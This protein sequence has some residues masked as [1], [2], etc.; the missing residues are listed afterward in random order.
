MKSEWAK[1]YS[2][3][4]NRRKL[5][6]SEQVADIR[7]QK[8]ADGFH[9]YYL[10]GI[11]QAYI[12]IIPNQDWPSIA[13]SHPAVMVWHPLSYV[14]SRTSNMPLINAQWLLRND[15]LDKGSVCLRSSA[16]YKLACRKMGLLTHTF[17]PRI[18]K[19]RRIPWFL[20]ESFSSSSLKNAPSC[21]FLPPFLFYRYP[22][23]F[24]LFV[25]SVKP[26]ADN[27][28]LGPV[29]SS[30]VRCAL[31]RELSSMSSPQL[32]YANQQ[33]AKGSSKR[34]ALIFFL[35]FMAHMI[36]INSHT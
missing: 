34:R 28:T 2:T 35:F 11:R 36:K 31:V 1:N 19:K 9:S 6:V 12:T 10:S 18:T 3:V 5:S 16:P 15:G 26:H 24:L 4:N 21:Q 30:S 29:Q 20:S 22:P 14:R 8:N 25:S 7:I 33:R 23:F 27:Y 32:W 13:H 17:A